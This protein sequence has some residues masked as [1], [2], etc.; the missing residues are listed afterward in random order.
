M[1][2]II[3]WCLRPH[4][5][6]MRYNSG[7]RPHTHTMIE[8]GDLGSHTYTMNYDREWLPDAPLIH[9]EYNGGLDPTLTQ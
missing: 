7:L 2:L 5:Y 4:L 3:E 9:N 1:F 8:N 6:I